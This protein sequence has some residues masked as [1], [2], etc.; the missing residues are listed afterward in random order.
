MS[1]TKPYLRQLLS[2]RSAWVE[3]ELIARAEKNG[4]GDVTMAMSRLCAHLGGRPLGLSEL[5]RRLSISRQA[6]HK[7]ANE[8]AAL[9]YVEFVDSDEDARV[10]LLRFTQK[11]WDMSEAAQA[12][13]ERI[14][15]EVADFIGHDK[16]SQLWE[17]L[18]MPWSSLE[19]AKKR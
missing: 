11:G 8:A 14:E 19:K 9:G 10:K 18:A 12:E 17:L 7:I 1:S 15:G 4:Y 3:R 6:V 13:L 2:W 16:A 5:G